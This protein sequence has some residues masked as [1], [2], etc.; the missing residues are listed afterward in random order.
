MTREKVVFTSMKQYIE[1]FPPEVQNRL[2]QVRNAIKAGTP[3]AKEG[4][5]YQI[6]AF[7]LDG[8]YFI[9]FAAWKNHI[10]VYPIPAGTPAFQK[11]AAR[12]RG[13]KS[14]LK[15]RMD[16]PLPLKFIER[17]AKFRAA[18]YC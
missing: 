16:K 5:S 13:T 8:T 6:P 4:I 18:E 1:S 14:T 15:F 9:G 11:Q 2:R 10:A 7:R 12:Y 3:R 17:A